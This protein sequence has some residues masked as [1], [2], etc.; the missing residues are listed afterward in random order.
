MK[1][2]EAVVE[3]VMSENARYALWIEPPGFLSMRLNALIDAFA[4]QYGGPRFSSHV[5]LLGG[6]SADEEDL[7]LRALGSLVSELSPFEIRLAGVGR[8]DSF[9]RCLYLLAEPT[10]ALK[11]ARDKAEEAFGGFRA[12]GSSPKRLEEFLPHMS[13]LYGDIDDSLKDAIIQ[14]IGSAVTANFTVEGFSLYRVDGDVPVWKRVGD[15]FP[16]TG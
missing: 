13:L 10:G 15:V 3:Y 12:Q 16:L 7:L 5:T 6:I 8:E 1:L 4:V 9:F 14:S 11:D 2:P